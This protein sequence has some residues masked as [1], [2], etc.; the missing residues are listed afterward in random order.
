M[1]RNP[2]KPFPMPPASV[3]EN[4][5][6]NKL[7]NY[8]YQYLCYNA[9]KAAES[10]VAEAL[11][12]AAPAPSEGPGFLMNWWLVFWDLYTAT[13]DRK[14]KDAA[15]VEAK[16]FMDY[17]FQGN[18]VPPFANQMNVGMAPNMS[19]YYRQSAMNA[20]NQAS[21]VPGG[22]PG[23]QQGFPPR[24]MG[25][26]G[27][28]PGQFVPRPGFDRMMPMHPNAA[29]GGR[30]NVRMGG[31]PYR[32]YM[33][34][35]GTPTFGN[36]MMNGTPISSTPSM[37]PSPGPS[38]PM[39]TDPNMSAQHYNMMMSQNMHPGQFAIMDHNSA[40]TPTS[41]SAGPTSVP[42]MNGAP[43]SV[44]NMGGPPSVGSGHGQMPS[45]V[46]G[47]NE[48]QPNTHPGS[49][50]SNM[51]NGNNEMDIKME[52]KQSPSNMVGVVNGGTPQHGGPGSHHNNGPPSAAALHGPNSVQSQPGAP[53]S[54]VNCGLMGPQSNPQNAQMTPTSGGDNPNMM[55]FGSSG[56]FHSEKTDGSEKEMISKIKASLIE[57]FK[58]QQ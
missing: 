3:N 6:R 43:A 42:A 33:D 30:M 8:V 13:P 38:G 36:G 55:D 16:A 17:T 37:M 27:Q 15:T 57:D 25:P 58:L 56:N 35:P 51:L 50:L 11:N 49:S 54:N 19:E 10:F 2:G 44:P 52:I 47:P 48:N 34:S 31:P 22:V 53:N 29:N 23:Y 28:V 5:A 4:E 1:H 40:G 21:P 39:P 45:S 18:G 7:N 32:Q 41:S 46:G 12:G 9:P 14:D 24:F 20:S 26:R